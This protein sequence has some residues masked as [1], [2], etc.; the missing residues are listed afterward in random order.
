[1]LVAIF[2]LC[3]FSLQ[4]SPLPADDD[5]EF[6][7]GVKATI[8]DSNGQA[9]HQI[10]PDFNLDWGHAAPDPRCS[11]DDLRTKL[12]A[13]LMI[14]KVGA[15]RFFVRSDGET[16]LK[17][18]G[19]AIKNDD[20]IDLPFGFNSVEIEYHHVKGRS[21]LTLEWQGLDFQREPVPTSLLFHDPV[22]G[23]S[24]K[25]FE[26]GRQFADRVGCANCHEILDL[27]RHPQL[28]PPLATLVGGLDERWLAEW[29]A[30]PAS[31]RAD[32]IM[33]S[34]GI[35]EQEARDLAAF[36][37]S[38]PNPTVAARDELR[39]AMNV[40]D[41]SEGKRLFESI[42]CLGC[43][44]MPGKTSQITPPVAP[45]LTNLSDSR[46]ASAVATFLV[47]APRNKAGSRHRPN[48]KVTPD[49]A[50]HL[51]AFLVS[52][53][54]PKVVAIPDRGDK[55]RGKKLAQ[56]YRCVA[57]HT[58][59][60]L[61]APETRIKL[62][63][64]SRVDRA[65][66]ASA[67]EIVGVVH[68]QKVYSANRLTLRQMIEKLPTKP[69]PTPPRTLAQDAI[70]RRN[71]LGCHSRDGGGRTTLGG[72]LAE[73]L[74]SD[75][76]LGSLKGMLTPPD[77]TAV[78][79]KLRVDYLKQTIKG[80]APK[81]RPWLAI[82]MP[83]FDYEPGEADAIASAFVSHDR[84]G[85]A[86]DQAIPLHKL[87]LEQENK[88]A[89]LIGQKGFGCINC[90]VL[91]GKIPPGGEAEMLGPDLALAHLRMSERYF[92]RWI[93]DP[94]RVIEGTP[95]PRF[96]QAINSEPGTFEEQLGTIWNLLG[97]D[98][99]SKVSAFGTR[100]LVKRDGDRA[101]IVRDMVVDENLPESAYVP[102]GIAFG[103]K[104]GHSLLFD[105]DKLSWLANWQGGFVYRTKSGRLW[106]WHPEVTPFWIAKRRASPLLFVKSDG[107]KIE[108]STLR[109]R[110]GSF[111][112]LEFLK[113]G[114]RMSYR[115]RLGESTE[116]KVIET[117]EPTESGWKRKVEALGLPAGISPLL[118]WPAPTKLWIVRRNSE[119]KGQGAANSFS[120]PMDAKGTGRFTIETEL[121][122]RP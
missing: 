66:L 15:Y 76:S 62:T 117:I 7:R 46:D 19:K 99:V 16:R 52:D 85:G 23:G 29:I 59:P 11:V 108:P 53:R 101:M 104:N 28:G 89:R 45:D 95:M 84:M 54:R 41:A 2:L 111:D 58:I 36:L 88:S 65:C 13:R 24:D 114:V 106:E 4:A 116:V 71:C 93:S 57:C 42:G 31:K 60:G 14:R 5:I 26:N 55:S 92:K 25:L 105:A 109:E 27:P 82:R 10:V 75:P 122:I 38:L 9:F 74:K 79:D 96:V 119:N 33:P 70:D 20:L 97:S 35:K 22:G 113:D 21:F 110:F 78:G 120:I 69:S 86:S 94:Q 107:M 3:S 118:N 18:A 63:S 98:R 83:V 50:A 44:T 112:D 34:L 80:D 73:A 61:M 103:L 121:S 49:E 51:A 37:K 67:S 6:A 115:L 64:A 8:K 81:A 91:A 43:H 68:L 72:Q 1:M 17:V 77:L 56:E 12:E 102:R 30:D 48:L 90:H 100:E 87:S 47:D 32:A 39:M 40:A